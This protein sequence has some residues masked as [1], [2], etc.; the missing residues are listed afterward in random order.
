MLRKCRS[1]LAGTGRADLWGEIATEVG[2]R[3]R[4]ANGCTAG[5][6]ASALGKVSARL[7]PAEAARIC[8]RSRSALAVARERRDDA[9]GA[10][11]GG[12]TVSNLASRME[13][14]RPRGSAARPRLLNRLPWS[15]YLDR[16]FWS[17]RAAKRQ[18]VSLV[19]SRMDPSEAAPLL[20]AALRAGGE[21]PTSVIS[22]GDGSS[23]VAG[24]FDAAEDA[25]LCRQ[26]CSS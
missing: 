18:C 5:Y 23:F 6:L 1:R 4:S 10:S 19:S 8:G 9:N 20:A 26:A 2:R 14:A 13:P 15:G 7:E 17:I 16:S 12:R 3:L 22:L 11:H 24:R 21:R 25:R